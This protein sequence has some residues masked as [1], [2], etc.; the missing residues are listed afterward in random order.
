MRGLQDEL[1][2]SIRGLVHIP[3]HGEVGVRA[4][5]GFHRAVQQDGPV[6][7]QSDAP[8][9]LAHLQLG[10]WEGGMEK[11]GERWVINTEKKLAWVP[12]TFKTF[13]YC[14][15]SLLSTLICS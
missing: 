10:H 2:I 9:R 11:C 14:T 8:L 12:S 6:L 5:L 4:G 3:E 15:K 1:P 13:R 7:Q